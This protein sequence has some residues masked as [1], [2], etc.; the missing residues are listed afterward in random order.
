MTSTGR[1]VRALLCAAP[2]AFAASGALA[3]NSGW[4]F[5]VSAYLW[6]NDTGVSADTP[7][8]NVSTELSFS[9]ALEDLSF[10]FMGTVEARNGRWGFISDLLYFSLTSTGEPPGPVFSGARVESK[11]TVSSNYAAYRLTED[12]N[13]AFD[14]AL[15]FRVFS[16]DVDVS[17]T[18]GSNPS[19]DQGDTWVDPLVAARLRM[20]FNEKW[21][22]T[23]LL[24]FG[25]TGDTS[26]WQALATVGYQ[27]NDSWSLVG[28]YRYLEAN[29]DTDFGSNSLDFSGP[30]LGATYRF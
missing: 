3:Q 27:L 13:L 4:T 1:L 25:G 17:L 19:F 5:G 16:G 6:V 7:F 11:I 8:G 2:I 20:A 23:L 12:E 14:V 10:A 30:L 22:G 15:G 29:W 18:G 21:F 28:G 24:D 26:S 9:D